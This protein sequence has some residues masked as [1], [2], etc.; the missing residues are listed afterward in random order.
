MK[1]L[2]KSLGLLVLSICIVCL[3]WGRSMN[4]KLTPVEDGGKR[5][6]GEGISIK[7]P[8]RWKVVEEAIAKGRSGMIITKGFS[9]VTV[10]AGEVPGLSTYSL[11]EAGVVFE[12]QLK[13][14]EA[15]GARIIS[16]SQ[17]TLEIGEAICFELES[18]VTQE[19]VD[20]NISSGI[21]SE[22]VMEDTKAFLDETI[23]EVAYYI[24]DGNHMIVVD[25]V[26]YNNDIA[27]IKEV[28]TFIANSIE[29]S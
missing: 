12:E 7:L 20:Q 26:T 27:G 22:E 28:A 19:M 5:V 29:L 3:G 24:I 1:S 6:M 11:E 10:V 9:T 25:A 2:K 16:S 13:A 4:E 21:Y 18:T 17:E 8:K 14:Q 23:Y 15:I